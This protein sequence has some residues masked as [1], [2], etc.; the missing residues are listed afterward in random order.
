MKGFFAETDKHLR[1]YRVG[2][3]EDIFL[4]VTLFDVESY[5]QFLSS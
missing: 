5:R 1:A 2:L 4:T 3:E